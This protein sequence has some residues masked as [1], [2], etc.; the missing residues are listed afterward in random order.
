MKGRVLR[1]VVT[2]ADGAAQAYAFDARQ[3]ASLSVGRV[4]S[5]AIV[6]PG[7]MA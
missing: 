2:G 1:L 7:T 4:A 5:S 6:L 3:P